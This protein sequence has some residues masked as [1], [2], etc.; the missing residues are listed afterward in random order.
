MLHVHTVLLLR[1]HVI[2]D[3]D[4]ICVICYVDSM[5]TTWNDESVGYWPG[6]L[7]LGKFPTRYSSPLRR[8]DDPIVVFWDEPNV[9]RSWLKEKLGQGR[10]KLTRYINDTCI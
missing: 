8:Q 1:Y 10:L 9:R 4:H 3:P 6:G 5:V 7:H 2:D